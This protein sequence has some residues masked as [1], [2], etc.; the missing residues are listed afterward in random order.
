MRSLNKHE[1][2]AHDGDFIVCILGNLQTSEFELLDPAQLAV[3]DT[4]RTLTRRGF[5][6]VGTV[7]MVNGAP[8]T[9]LDEPL[10]DATISTLSSAYVRH[11]TAR[12]GLGRSRCD[13]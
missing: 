12:A 3:A 4:A 13:A 8:R 5:Q 11:V 10:D 7:G 1:Q 6:Y 9:A 2:L